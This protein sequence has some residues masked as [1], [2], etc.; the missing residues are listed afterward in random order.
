M[1]GRTI[2]CCAAAAVCLAGFP[3]EAMAEGA[4]TG[5]NLKIE[6]DLEVGAYCRER[7]IVITPEE[8][9]YEVE[10]V[11]ILND[12][13]CWGPSDV[14][15]V[16]VIL[17]AEEGSV[18]SLGRDDICLEGARLEYWGKWDSNDD[19]YRLLF[20]LPS[21]REKVGEISSASWS[22]QTVG[23]WEAAYN[24][25]NYEIY[26]FRDG[27]SAG[28]PIYCE[29]CSFDFG[30]YMRKAGSYTYQVRAIN[31]VD[32]KVK[33]SWKESAAASPIDDSAAEQISS[34]Y[35][36]LVPEGITEP[37]QMAEMQAMLYK[38]TFGWIQEGG[39][40]WYRNPDG[41]YT[42]SNWQ[43]IDGKWYFFDSRGY[44][45]TGWID[46]NGESYYCDPE[47]G[48]MLTGTVVPDGMG[49]RVDSTGALIR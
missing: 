47:S 49:Q 20:K 3:S 46:W 24:A 9:S 44:M 4:I 29:G 37:G 12:I 26:L 39:R 14:P 33:S 2:L 17:K 36:P 34:R 19:E 48:A 21:M 40:W 45:V 30:R 1:R 8:D 27:K 41:S 35:E 31:A 28:R 5:I 23:T 11:E 7:D 32:S 38:D 22:S 42:V 43:M 15:R 10:S 16:S 18:F 13:V 25:G 6:A